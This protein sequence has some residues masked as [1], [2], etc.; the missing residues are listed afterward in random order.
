MRYR[1]SIASPDGPDCTDQR[2]AQ[3][4]EARDDH[5]RDDTRDATRQ[6]GSAGHRSYI[7]T[8]TWQ[9][10]HTQTARAEL[11]VDVHD[12]IESLRTAGVRC[13]A[14]CA[15]GVWRVAHPALR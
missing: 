8:S 15:C 9:R 12:P 2:G 13:V 6:A 10:G 3:A 14:S 1:F 11:T 5:E 4:T 7:R